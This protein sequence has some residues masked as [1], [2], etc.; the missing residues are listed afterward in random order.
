MLWKIAL[1]GISTCLSCSRTYVDD[2]TGPRSSR[3]GSEE[4]RRCGF[5]RPLLVLQNVRHSHQ[6]PRQHGPRDLSRTI[7]LASLIRKLS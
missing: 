5:T 7:A 3:H 2:S 4:N 6:A 1:N